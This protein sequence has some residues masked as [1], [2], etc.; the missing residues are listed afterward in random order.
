MRWFKRAAVPLSLTLRDRE[1]VVSKGEARAQIVRKTICDCPAASGARR[2][3]GYLTVNSTGIV[4]LIEPLLI[5]SGNGGNGAAWRS[6]D[7]A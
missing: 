6:M 2:R 1:A 7:M 4:K 5:S 3:K